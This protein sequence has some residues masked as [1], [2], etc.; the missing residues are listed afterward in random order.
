MIIEDEREPGSNVIPVRCAEWLNDKARDVYSQNGEDG[1]LEAVFEKIGVTNEWC[2]EVGAYD[3]VTFSNARQFIAKG[4]EAAL[5]EKDE[6]SFKTLQGNYAANP[7]VHCA[8]GYIEPWNIDGLL[9]KMGL[10]WDADL[11]VLD[12]DEQ[13]FWV[14]CGMHYTHPRVMVVEYGLGRPVDQIP[15]LRTDKGV[16]IPGTQAGKNAIHYMGVCKG[17]HCV[18]ITRT[19]MIFIADGISALT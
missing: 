10:P 7:R 2:F 3:G 8:Q 1:L 13:E 12:I 19:N 11:G 17:Y 16:P 9:E 18:A 5:I 14:W 4:W 6:E 15:P